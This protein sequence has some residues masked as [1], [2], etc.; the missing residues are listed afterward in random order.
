MAHISFLNSKEAGNVVNVS[1]MTHFCSA[2]FVLIVIQFS[3]C[4]HFVQSVQIA[5]LVSSAVT[6]AS[7]SGL[8]W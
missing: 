8:D 5:R 7:E 6:L 3:D 1:I 2:V 4:G